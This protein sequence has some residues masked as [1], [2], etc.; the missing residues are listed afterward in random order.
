MRRRWIVGVLVGVSLVAVV[1]VLGYGRAVLG[2]PGVHTNPPSTGIVGTAPR[3]PYPPAPTIPVSQ[4]PIYP[5]PSEYGFSP[6]HLTSDVPIPSSTLP[7]PN[8]PYTSG[9][10]HMVSA[11]VFTPTMVKDAFVAG[12]SQTN[13]GGFTVRTAWTVTPSLTVGTGYFQAD[14]E[15]GVITLSSNGDVQLYD[16]IMNGGP[17]AAYIVGVKGQD[18]IMLQGA[19]YVA[20]NYVTHQS[21]ICDAS[22]NIQE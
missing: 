21:S 4:F 3:V 13:L 9:E 1:G 12:F 18:V 10:P 8:P 7:F 17:G 14:Q 20:W 6:E 22:G 15:P 16:I 5:I 19:G 2:G 11:S